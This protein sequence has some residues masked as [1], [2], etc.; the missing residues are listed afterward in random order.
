MIRQG[1]VT[2]WVLVEKP[3]M[4]V[5]QFVA[6]PTHLRE[7]MPLVSDAEVTSSTP[8]GFPES[9]RVTLWPMPFLP[10][11]AEVR[12]TDVSPGRMLAYEAMQLGIVSS[13]EFE[14]TSRGTIVRATYTPW[15]GLALS[16]LM[17]LVQPFSRELLEQIL[18]LLKERIE[19]RDSVAPERLVFFSYRREEARYVGGRICSALALEFGQDA[20]F[21]DV[22][23]ILPGDRW[24][25]VLEKELESCRVVV[26]LFGRSWGRIRRERE[27]S[28]TED[29]V[30]RELEVALRARKLV[31]PVY[32]DVEDPRALE[33][34]IASGTLEP[35]RERQWH[36]LRE[37]PDFDRDM[38][39]LI[40][41][42]WS[43]ISRHWAP[44]RGTRAA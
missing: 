36:R 18:L 40:A 2:A 34:D 21:R 13:Y 7:W 10:V 15:A 22:N 44:R 16:P 29:W 28:G 33:P 43:E 19:S 23:T 25:R 9:F 31:I 5:F 1:T 26:A 24:E 6:D 14:P 4:D 3:I 20:V 11:P 38:E 32:F 41:A 12:L 35:L 17:S 42:V 27:R 39:A 30:C 37:D 8:R